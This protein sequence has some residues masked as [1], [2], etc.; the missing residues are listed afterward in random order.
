MSPTFNI[1]AGQVQYQFVQPKIDANGIVL[2]I[3]SDKLE[4]AR[5][6]LTNQFHPDF[7]FKLKD[8]TA[9]FVPLEVV[10]D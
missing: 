6:A 8:Q 9:Q 2:Q 4:T 3:K 7:L 5:N 10:L 1:E